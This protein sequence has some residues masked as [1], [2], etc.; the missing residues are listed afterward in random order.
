MFPL[1]SENSKITG[2]EQSMPICKVSKGSKWLK[3]ESYN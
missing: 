2:K 1:L 3:Q